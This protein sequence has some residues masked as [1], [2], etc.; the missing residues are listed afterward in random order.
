[1]KTLSRE[2]F[3]YQMDSSNKPQIYVND[4]DILKVETS[5]CFN[6]QISKEG[7][8]L[9]N[10][11]FESFNPATGPIYVEGAKVGD[12]LKV[13]VL[14][15]NINDYGVISV[16]PDFGVTGEYH[17]E[18]KTKIIPII[19]NKAVF[20]DKISLDV[21]PMIGVIGTAPAN[22][23][24]MTVVPDNHGGNMDC[25]RITADSAVFLPVNVEGGLLSIGD[26][27]AVMGDG[28]VCGCGVEI[29]GDVTIRVEVLKN[30]SLPLPLVATKESIMTI[31]SKE[32]LDEAS[33]QATI[34]MY[35]FLVN[36]LKL[37]NEEAS[38]LLSVAGD[39]K[40]CQIVN[41]LK[42]ARFEIR[43]SV[44]SHYD[45]KL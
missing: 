43:K 33:K 11:D 42:T 17:R 8:I 34:N 40:V 2:N 41:P 10:T 27:H 14:E 30:K 23:S 24:I 31:S 7:D 37:S 15:I 22:K 29:K 21:E 25:K 32:T 1:M 26:L 9:T 38:M 36:E 19:K 4:G 13:H 12:I 35:S 16:M 45:Y 5:D 6:G 39:L 28:E 20:N 18:E 3:V 44:L